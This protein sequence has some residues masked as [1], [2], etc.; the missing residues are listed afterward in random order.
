[1]QCWGS[2]GNGRLGDG[3]QHTLL[4]PVGVISLSTPGAVVQITAGG[5][6]TCAIL[7]DNTVK[8]W[9]RNGNGQLGDGST[10]AQLTPVAVS[11][12]STTNAAVYAVQIRLVGIIRAPSYP[13]IR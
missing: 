11:T 1:M 7:S 13:I 12:L 5:F 4:T 8:C 6:H 2:N 9:G 3:T 10:V